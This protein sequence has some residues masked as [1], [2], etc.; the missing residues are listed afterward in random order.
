MANDCT[1]LSAEQKEFLHSLFDYTVEEGL[2]FVRKQKELVSTVNLN[3]VSSL[4]RLLNT[5]FAELDEGLLSNPNSDW[6]T[7]FG[8]LFIFS[9]TWSIAGNLHESCHDAFD[10]FSRELFEKGPTVDCPIPSGTTI[11]SFFVHLKQKTMVPWEELV[12]PFQY[13]SAVPYFEIMVP[14]VDTLRFQFLTDRL[15]KHA[16]PT[17]FTGNTGVGKSVIIQDLLSRTAKEKNYIPV[18]LNFSAQTSSA[19]TQRYIELKLEKK[20]KN[21]MGAPPNS[22]IVIFVDDL[23]MPKLDTYGA[24]PPIELLRQFI[25]TNGFYDREKLTWKVIEDV[26]VLSACAPPGGGRNPVTPRLLRHFNVLN[27][28]MPSDASLARIFKSILDGFLKPFPTDVRTLSEAMVNSCIEL[29]NRMCTE[30][31]PTPAKSH[32]TFNLRDLSKVVQGITQV[33]PTTTLSR[34]QGVALFAHEAARVFHDRLID[35]NDR[36]YFTQLMGELVSKSFSENL[37]SDPIIFGDFSKRGVPRE[38]RLY[39]Q[40]TDINALGSLLEDYLEEYNVTL[41]RDMRLTFFLDA[42]Q[43]VARISRIIRQPRGNGLLVGVGGTGKKSLTRLAC[44]MSEYQCLEIELTRTYGTVEWREDIKKLFKLAGVEGKNTVFLLTDTQVKTEAFLED[45]NGMLNTGDVPNLFDLDERE[46]VIGAIRQ[47]A[48]EKGYPE[49]RDSVYQF[50]INRVRDNLH[51]VF[52]TSPVGDTFRNRCRMFPSLV[53]CCTIDW[54]DEWP[55]DALLSVSKRFLEF[56]ELGDSEMKEKISAMCVEV[57]TSVSATATRYYAE[58]RRRFYTTP[59]SYL[60][61]IGLYITMLQ[62]KR[63]EIGNAR[64]RLKNGLLK[65]H[66]TNELVANMQVTL[67]QLGPELKQKAA[68]VE[69]LMIKIGKDQETADGVKRVVAEEEK[70]VKQQAAQTEAIAREA[71]KDLDEALPALEAAYKALDS[72]EKKDVAEMK[73]FAKPPELVVLVMEAVC[74]LFKAKPDWDSSKKLLGD[75]QFLKRIQEFDKESL[76]DAIAKKLKK[77]IENPSFTPEAV[78]KVSRAARSMCMWVLAMD[79]YTRVNKEVEPKRKRLLEAQTSLETTKAKLDEKTRQLQEVEAQLQQLKQQYEESIASKKTLSEKMEQ[80]QKRLERASKL[81]TALSDEQIRWTASVETLSKQLE[82]VVGT[83][84]VGAACVAYFGAFTV[85]YRKDMISHWITRC[86]EL[87]IPVSES[88]A[89]AE[90]LGDPVQVREWNLQGLPADELSTEN[91]ILVTRGRRW[92]LMIDPQGQ[93]NRWIRNMEGAADLKILKLSDPKFLRALE[94]AVRMGQPVLIE[95]VGEQLDP[96]IEP[97]LLKQTIRQGGRLLMKLGDSLVEYDKNFKM[98][99]TTKLANPHY[100]PEVCIKVTVIN[101]TVTQVGLEGQLMADVVKLERPEL[102]EQR[103]SL[104]MSISNDKRQLKEIEEKILRLLYNS[105]G[106]IL[107]DEE[108]IITL[109]QSKVT[110]AAIT[111]RLIQAE[112]TEKEINGAREKYRPVALRGSI[113]Y[114]VIASLAEVDQMYQFSLKYFKNLFTQCIVDSPKDQELSVHVEW[115]CS[116][117]M[118]SVFRNVSR[119][120][121]EQHKVIFSFMICVSVMRDRKEIS[122]DDWNFFLRGS[123]PL[124]LQIPPK[125][126]ARWL[127]D[128]MWKNCC[129]LSGSVKVFEELSEHVSTHTLEW[130]E[131]IEADDPYSTLVPGISP[132][133]ISNFHKLLLVKVLREEMVIQ[134][135]IG[136]IRDNIGSSYIDLPPLDLKQVYTDMNASTPL[137]F[138]LS[139]GSDPVSGLLK[140]AQSLGFSERLHMISLGQGQGPIAEA[141]LTKALESGDWLFLQNCHLAASWM[142]RLENRVKEI[143]SLE[144]KGNTS[145]RLFLSSMPSKVFPISVLQESVKVTNEPPKGLRSNLARSFADISPQLFDTS[146]PQGSR[147]RKLAFSLCFFNAIVQERKKF[148]PLGWNIMYDWSN[149][150]LEVSIVVLKNFLTKSN[151][152]PWD[153]LRYLTGEITFGGR[154]TDDWDRR[155]MRTLLHK[156]YNVDIL[157]DGYSLSPSG[158][159]VMPADGLLATFRAHIDKLPFTEEPSVFG[160]HENANVSYQLQETKRLLRTILDVQPRIVSS[161]QGKSPEER[162]IDVANSILGRVPGL[163]IPAIGRAPSAGKTKGKASDMFKID[164]SGRMLNSLSTVLCQ[165][166]AR[167][168]KLIAV[169]KSSLENLIKAIRGLVVMSAQLDLVYQSLLNNEVSILVL[170][171]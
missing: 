3:L 135:V 146:P 2:I 156:Y 16:Y 55:R 71:Q 95:D 68:D 124:N 153:A 155:T 50:F 158:K 67:Q 134:S 47:I 69:T 59:T 72:L 150:D 28:P 5:F 166:C 161:G 63:R 48:R 104:I 65:L 116:N 159:Y 70:V 7:L 141:L 22:R 154:V 66:E 56:V 27:I 170:Q 10:T 79:I 98:Y 9:Y 51:I 31:L 139:S 84:F 8:Y 164:E 60:E 117:I 80:T 99:I 162:A 58:L 129:A 143:A 123:L 62:E 94:N 157:E 140:L 111:E 100:L 77:Y 114:F 169:I 97:L 83:V 21:I 34:T 131:Y 130:E 152:I 101:F 74:I 14:T 86:R 144:V 49:D 12:T 120:L 30:L 41:S 112:H 11:F 45:V 122:D 57:H 20:K 61:L 90:Q 106:N 138:V 163:L 105:Q 160:M 4:C 82:D 88:F 32:Y 33:K 26:S 6:K 168:N 23:N 118:I 43:H 102:E 18:Y 46:Q 151:L 29:Y 165:E 37:S 149:S 76:N 39:L 15:L 93:A 137:I 142:T 167:F 107:D 44:H 85:A 54:F 81:T 73:A 13:S 52:A 126:A 96:A 89:L 147:F 24:Q 127:T 38:E 108:L 36:S 121:F 1:A 113:L 35:S 119:G 92:P 136:F 78:E 171:L 91:G 128:A 133:K 19:L 25:D 64:D 53:N 132:D 75:P 109:N 42:K 125:P 145:F 87:G 148:G 103:N 115:L 40:F 17:L 110:S